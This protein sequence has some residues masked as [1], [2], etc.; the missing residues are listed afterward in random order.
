MHLKEIR[1]KPSEIKKGPFEEGE[2]STV[3]MSNLAIDKI[4]ATIGGK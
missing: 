2:F 4:I 1:D 3:I